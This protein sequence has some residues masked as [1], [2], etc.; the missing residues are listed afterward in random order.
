MCFDNR[1]NRINYDT[2]VIF[3]DVNDFKII[4]DTYGHYA[5]DVCLIVIAEAIKNAYSKIGYCYRY[6]GDEFIVVLKK[7]VL[8]TLTVKQNNFDKYKAIG[9]ISNL[10][11]EELQKKRENI[12]FLPSVS[13][14]FGIF[15]Y[16]DCIQEV[17]KIA[18]ERM[19]E[20]KKSSKKICNCTLKS[21]TYA[22][23]F[24]LFIL[25]KFL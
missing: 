9:D 1:L 21:S 19:Y 22:W 8:E 13:S 4:N 15:S 23:G 12:E 20:K 11:E 5:G 25:I 7:G 18:D 16:G 10:L 17:I 24:N 2:A 3:I 6:G 14:G